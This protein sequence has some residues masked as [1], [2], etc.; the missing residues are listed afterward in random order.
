MF[1]CA[2]V[3]PGTKSSV[4][5][6]EAQSLFLEPPGASWRHMSRALMLP[7]LHPFKPHFILA[8]SFTL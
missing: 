3:T 5:K 1:V 4:K 7:L 8:E 6:K 2:L